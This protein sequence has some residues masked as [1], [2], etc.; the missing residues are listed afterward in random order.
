ME[1]FIRYPHILDRIK[2]VFADYL[3]LVFFMYILFLIFSKIGEISDTTRIIGFVFIVGLYDP[4]MISFFGG[5]IG[6]YMT[7][8]RVKRKQNQDK[9]LMLHKALFRYL[10][11]TTL[12]WL[13]LITVGTNKERLAIHDM[14][15]KSIVVYH[16]K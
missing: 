13:S 12:G 8:I 3:V 14:I 9:N 15:S 6:H 11:K 16:K 5:T 1:D 10:I 7:N 4:L 2:A